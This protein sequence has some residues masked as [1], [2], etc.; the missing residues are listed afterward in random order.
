MVTGSHEPRGVSAAFRDGEER[1]DLR[2]RRVQHGEMLR[3]LA[4]IAETAPWP[5]CEF[6]SD[7]I[8]GIVR[9]A[10]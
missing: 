2:L 4:V 9:W 1:A 5:T 8:E 3:A 6:A 7:T 10:D